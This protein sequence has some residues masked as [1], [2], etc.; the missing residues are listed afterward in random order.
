[1]VSEPMKNEVI[2]K[3]KQITKAFPGVMALEMVDFD[4]RKG[5]VHCIAGGNGAGKSTLIKILSGVYAPTSGEIEFEG[6]TY[7]ELIPTLSRHLGIQTIYQETLLAPTLT[8]AENIFLGDSRLMKNGIVDWKT[9]RQRAR[10]ILD[11]MG[12]EIDVGETVENLGI[13]GKQSVQIAK[14]LANDAKV[15]IFD[16]P[17]ASFGENETEKLFQIINQLRSNGVGIIYISHRLE[18]IA[19]IADRISVFKDGKRVGVHG[20]GDVSIDQLILEMV[21]LDSKQFYEREAVPI[22]ETVLSVNNLSGDGVKNASFTLRKGEVLGIGGMVGSRRTELMKLLFG[23]GHIESGEVVLHGKKIIPHSPRQMI[24]NGFCMVT[25]DRAITG[26]MLGRNIRENSVIARFS[27]SPTPLINSREEGKLVQEKMKQLNIKA[28]SPAQQV[29]TLSGGNQ[30]KVILGKWL[31]TDGEIFIMD[32]PTRGIDIGA[33]EE[34]YKLIVEIAKQGGSVLLVSSDTMELVSMSDR[35]VVM[36]DGNTA[37]ILE[38]ED[39]SEE[40]IMRVI[41]S[42]GKV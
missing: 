8:V 22:G 13:A 7:K 14:A 42:G 3:L 29:L 5:E 37:G 34:I 19:R 38:K 39:I 27:K 30:Q 28:T 20:Q 25:E 2:L 16:E 11:R 35:I 12:V 23:A 17:T 36:R 32:E 33:K 10:E 24:R 1:M 41:V 21:G 40:N 4:L 31:L 15:M 9:T 6:K 26:L 18:E